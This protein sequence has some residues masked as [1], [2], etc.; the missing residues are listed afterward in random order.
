MI[1]LISYLGYSK[2]TKIKQEG[3]LGIGTIDNPTKRMVYDKDRLIKLYKENQLIANTLLIENNKT[4][5]KLNRSELNQLFDAIDSITNDQD[6]MNN[7]I[8][9]I[10]MMKKIEN[11]F[12]DRY[13]PIWTIHINQNYYTGYSYGCVSEGKLYYRYYFNKEYAKVLKSKFNKK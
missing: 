3:V 4:I 7:Y 2:E 5:S 10:Q 11:V 6:T 13:E 1:L 9:K 8:Y 12:G